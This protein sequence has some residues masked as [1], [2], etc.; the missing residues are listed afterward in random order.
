VRDKVADLVKE[1]TT[2]PATLIV[3]GLSLVGVAILVFGDQA[4]LDEY[5]SLVEKLEI[6]IAGLAAGR[7]IA[8]AGKANPPS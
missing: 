2:G 3:Y 8:V 6:P 4:A 1:I 7:G 5:L